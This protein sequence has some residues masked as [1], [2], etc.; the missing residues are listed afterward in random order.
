[1]EVQ[2]YNEAIMKRPWVWICHLVF[3]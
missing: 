2:L 3:N 1:M